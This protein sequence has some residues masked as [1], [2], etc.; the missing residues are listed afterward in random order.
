MLYSV[1]SERMLMEQLEYNLLFRWFV[2]LSADEPV[3]H[4]S[5][6]AKNRDR[7]LEGA[8]SEE[9]FSLILTQARR[10]KLLADEHLTVDGMLIEAWAGQK[11]FRRKDNDND[12]L[13]PPPP[14]RSS[15]P[16]VKWHK[17]KRSNDPHHSVTDP[18]ARLYK[19]TR[20]SGA[21]LGY[22]GHSLTEN[23]NGL[24]VDAGRHVYGAARHV[25][26]G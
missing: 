5:V 22:P 1:R 18:M 6:F 24:V 10:K 16:T 13:N 4:R 12:P 19:K 17:E 23:R 8:A 21:R 3:W 14:D 26:R 9:F 15:N 11:S 7:L 20:G 25:R 2:G